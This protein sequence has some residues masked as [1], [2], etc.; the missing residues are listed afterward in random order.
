L[1]REDEG[2]RVALYATRG[3]E[4]RLPAVRVG[5]RTLDVHLRGVRAQGGDLHFS[6]IGAALDVVALRDRVLPRLHVRRERRRSGERRD[7]DDGEREDARASH[8]KYSCSPSLLNMLRAAK[9][10]KGISRKN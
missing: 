1:D 8:A 10:I 9:E 4:A 3:A 5:V 2:H 7:G 6:P